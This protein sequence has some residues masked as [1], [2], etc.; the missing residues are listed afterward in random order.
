MTKAELAEAAAGSD[1]PDDFVRELVKARELK[2]DL[3]V[4]EAE[5]AE[6]E[7]DLES[8]ASLTAALAKAGNPAG[9]IRKLAADGHRFREALA[10]VPEAIQP[11]D[12]FEGLSDV[13]AVLG[14]AQDS[15]LEP[16]ELPDLVREVGQSRRD[17]STLRGQIAKLR[18][19]LAGVGKGGDFPPCWVTED[20]RVEFLFN[21]TLRADGQLVVVDSTP[22]YRIPDRDALGVG[23]S[24]FV[25]SQ[26]KGQFLQLTKPIYD[27]SVSHDC[28]FFVRITD[29]T[30]DEQKTLFKDL[31][32]TV[33]SHFYK[34][35][36]S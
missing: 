36:T 34:V 3:E 30:R 4:R 19:D 14:A 6:R 5:L 10:N 21:V 24:L 12:P 15:A 9:E 22:A 31:L 35:L 8:S 32:R 27:Y 1:I 20:G 13:M 23:A 7:S 11:R 29:A 16:A 33:E 28:R 26:A 18:S 25:G 2:A 17:I